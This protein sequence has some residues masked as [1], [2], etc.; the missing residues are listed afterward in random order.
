MSDNA[1]DITQ[2]QLRIGPDPSSVDRKADGSP[3]R[4]YW[5]LP[6]DEA[7]L[8]AFLRDVFEN[9]WQGL[10]FGP[11]IQG[12]A[13]ELRCPGP[14]TKISLFDGYLTVMFERGGHFHLCIGENKGSERFPVSDDLRA[15]RRPS[16]A[17]IFRGFGG[18]GHPVTWG[19]EMTN[20]KDEPMISIFFPN[21]FINEDDSLAETPRVVASRH[22]AH[23]FENMARAGGR[24]ARQCRQ[25]IS[26]WCQPLKP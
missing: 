4:E 11:L 1:Q 13:Y 3:S 20:G 15:H 23:D 21:P 5:E 24:S 19:F 17:R 16:K 7:Y 22:V 9:H 8:H 14:P 12:A 6:L 26:S 10:C 18:D 25:G 2:Q